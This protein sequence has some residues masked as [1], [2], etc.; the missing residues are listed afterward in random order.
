MD[1]E[2][3]C[4]RYLK[5]G[6]EHDCLEQNVRS[7][8]RRVAV[9]SRTTKTEP[10]EPNIVTRPQKLLEWFLETMNQMT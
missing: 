7:T 9:D 4:R 5:I 1:S 3:F 2:V 10:V 6:H 8:T